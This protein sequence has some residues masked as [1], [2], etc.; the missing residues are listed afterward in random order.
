MSDY[1]SKL[2]T[3]GAFYG[4]RHVTARALLDRTRQK[5]WEYR[6]TG[7][8]LRA[9]LEQTVAAKD[10]AEAVAGVATRRSEELAEAL[11]HAHEQKTTAEF[12]CVPVAG[13]CA[14]RGRFTRPHARSLCRSTLLE[15]AWRRLGALQRLLHVSGSA[16]GPPSTRAQRCR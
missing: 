15:M 7:D 1:E 5:A 8:A 3:K 6:K 16:G 12:G 4:W 11:A 14:L 13:G 10:A 2:V 9:E